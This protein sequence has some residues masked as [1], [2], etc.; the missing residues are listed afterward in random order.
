VCLSATD[1][2]GVTKT[3][4]QDFNPQLVQITMA[5]QPTGLKLHI[6]ED[7]IDAGGNVTG[8]TTVTSWA[9]YPLHITAPNQT[10]ASGKTE[11]FASWSDGLAQTHVVTPTANATY[12]ATFSTSTGPPPI[13]NGGFE[14]GD[15]TGWTR[16]GTT[17]ITTSAPHSGLDAA[18]LGSANPT[19]GDSKVSQTFTAPTGASAVS[20]FYNLNCPDD[21][22]YDWATAS[23]KDNTTAVTTTPLA[24]TCTVGAGWKQVS[25]PVTPG[26]SYTL[27]L[28]SHDENNPGDATDTKFDDVSV[29]G[30]SAVSD[31]SISAAPSSVSVVAGNSASSTI[32]TATTSGTA[33]TVALSASGA[34]AGVSVAFNPTSVTSGGSSAMS[35]S[36]ATSTTPGSYPITIS[37]TATSGS[38]TV[39]FTL[40]VSAPVTGG[41]VNGGFETGDFTGW[42]RSGTT[43]ITTSGPHSGTDAVLLGLVSTQTNGDSKVTQTFT[44]PTATSHVSFY[45]NLNCP[46]DVTYDWA[47]ATLKDNT[48]AVT[49]TVLAKTCTVGAGWKQISASIVAGHSYTLTLISHDENNP[50]DATSTKYDDVTLS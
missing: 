40:T 28:V 9:G 45:Y 36:T 48:T 50:G 1:S 17:A 24:K 34:P 15:F 7:D 4:E 16:S 18:L 29:N 3:I 8:P 10:D 14:T 38:H 42:T 44:A 26:H 23:L 47:T 37:G 13:V 46:D 6:D 5:S 25:A 2:K 11:T 43:A 19:N 22:A 12:S 31:F 39:T 33:Q 27:T 35:I 49:T 20:F 41:V 30:S 32:S 21:V